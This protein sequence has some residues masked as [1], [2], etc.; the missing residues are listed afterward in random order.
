MPDSLIFPNRMVHLDFHTGPDIR[1]VGRDFDA[2][3]FARTFAD[4]HVDSVTVFAKCHHGHLYYETERPERHPGLAS[5]LDLLG[6]QV[7]ALHR[8]GIRAPIYLS[9]QV[10]EWAARQHPEWVAQDETG[11]LVKAGGPFAASWHTLDMSSPYQDFLADQLAEALEKFAPVDGIFMDMCWDQP[12]CTKWAVDGMRK[13]GYEPTDQADRAKYAREVAYGYMERYRSMLEEAQRGHEAAGIWF[14]SRPKTNLAAETKYLRHI[15]VEC[16]PTGGW[17]Y[18]YFP[19]VARYVRPFGLPTLSHTGRFHTTWGDFGGI[20]PE[21][22]LRYECASILSQG[23]TSGV[24]DQLHPRGTLDKAAYQLIGSVYKHIE[25]CEPYVTGG[26]LLSQ[27]A[28]LIDPERGDQPGPDGLGLIR[29][30]QQLRQQFDLLPP[31]AAVQNYEMVIVPESV[32][33]SADD[34]AALGKYLDNGGALIAVGDGALGENGQPILDALGI[35]SHGESP[36]TATYLRVR[37]AVAGGLPPTD[38]IMYDRGFRMTARKGAEVLCDI[39]QPYFERTYEHFCS[40]GQTPPADVSPYAAVVQNG[41]AIT[42][43]VP[44]FSAYGKY[45]NL[46][47]RQ[48]LRNCLDRLLP[49][50]LVRDDGPSY[51]ET[52]VVQA[53]KRTIVHLLSFLPARRTPTLDLIEDQLPLIEMPISIKLAQAP[54]R[55][56]LAPSERE[57]PVEYRDGRAHVRITL[58]DGHGMVVFE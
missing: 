4:A 37:P 24:G 15:E 5:G 52:T 30:L 47:Y 20:K 29:A 35:E 55:A 39:V 28:V 14:N 44:L 58:L 3:E 46:P 13:R 43:S 53:G 9:V 1:D 31:S 48:L 10:D 18:A 7:E 25:D 27:I 2:E 56:F 8:Y 49:E 42:I 40:H 6:Q 45:G 33:L 17:G 32:H 54:R 21:A 22:A 11:C 26:T 51:L 36:F 34:R 50:P 23:M 16:L 41:R 38:H 19:Y 12:S 57:L